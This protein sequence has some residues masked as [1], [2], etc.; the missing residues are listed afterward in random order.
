MIRN[1]AL[2]KQVA[3]AMRIIILG[4]GLFFI[5]GFIFSMVDPILG[6][7]GPP[8][9]TRTQAVVSAI[10]Q[11]VYAVC[12]VI[13]P[14]VFSRK[15]SYFLGAV[16]FRG[17]GCAVILL[18]IAKMLGGTSGGTSQVIWTFIITGIVL[19]APAILAM[20]ELF[21]HKNIKQQNL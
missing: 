1:L 10:W 20:V 18:G 19:V 5:G 4:L 8:Y 6:Y 21:L 12:L 14:S 9:P 16:T 3:I 15:R 13:P 17:L 2:P 11:V 7:S